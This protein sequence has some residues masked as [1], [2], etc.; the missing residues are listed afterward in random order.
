MKKI[1]ASL[2]FLSLIIGAF[3]YSSSLAHDLSHMEAI[4][5]ESQANIDSWNCQ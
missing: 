1:Q 3:S 4:T 2:I 5:Y